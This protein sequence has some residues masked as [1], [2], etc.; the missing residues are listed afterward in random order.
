MSNITLYQSKDDKL[1][2][3]LK[4]LWVSALRNGTFTKGRIYLCAFDTKDQQFQYCALGVLLEI[5]KDAFDVTKKV[6]EEQNS[7]NIEIYRYRY[8]DNTTALGIPY[9]ILNII[10][11]DNDQTRDITDLND[12][13]KKSFNEIA[14]YIEQNL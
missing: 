8:Q 7:E 14:D 9:E 2:P 13:D 10:G 1:N 12:K 6:Q 11:L 4:E 5:I 3:Y